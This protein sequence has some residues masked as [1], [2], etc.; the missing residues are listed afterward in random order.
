MIYSLK[1][2]V[3]ET[4]PTAIVLDVQGVG[5]MVFCTQHARSR[6]SE[7]ESIQVITYHHIRE[8]AQVLY[9][10]ESA[11]ERQLFETLISVS[12]IGPKVAMGILSS[13]KLTDFIQAIQTEN[14]MLI[15]QIPGIGKKTAERMVIELKDKIQG[16]IP[17]SPQPI[18]SESVNAQPGHDSDDI[19][20]A[21]R[22]LGYQ[23]EEIK[24][25]FMKHAT[26]LSQAQAIE[27]QIKILL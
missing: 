14:I 18:Q 10:F 4:L 15:T 3:I 21:L 11:T 19:V 5:Y 24:R 8:D 13:V 20:L 9:G 26:E 27:D 16:L 25:T 2:T 7:G 23:K 1:G 22:Q 12:G 6:W 17:S